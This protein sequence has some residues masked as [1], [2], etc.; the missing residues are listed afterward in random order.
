MQSGFSMATTA[1]ISI[2]IVDMIQPDSKASIIKEAETEVNYL[3]GQFTQG[4]ITA[5]ERL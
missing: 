2:S 3:D 5:G 4:L 1:G